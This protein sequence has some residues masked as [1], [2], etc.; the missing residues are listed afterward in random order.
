MDKCSN[1]ESKIKSGLISGYNKAYDKQVVQFINDFA[2][3]DKNGYCES[4]G[5]HLLDKAKESFAKLTQ[6]KKSRIQKMLSHMPITTIQSP[7]NWDYDIGGIVSG[8][9]TTGTGIFSDISATVAD[10][11]GTQA[12]TYNNKIKN[13]ENICKQ[14][15]RSQALSMGCNAIVAVD[16]D[17]SELGSLKGMIMVCMSGT[18]IKLKNLNV[19]SGIVATNLIE[20]P[21]EVEDLKQW[22]LKYE[23]AKGL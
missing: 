4:C 13:G 9:S 1:C 3:S 22:E 14:Q 23:F 6:E 12:T 21:S 7:L 11:F 10:I 8:Q 19:L 20:I 16:I 5:P 2:P 15:L 17:Y 18:A